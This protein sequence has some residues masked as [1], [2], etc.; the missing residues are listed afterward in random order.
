MRETPRYLPLYDINEPPPP[1][2]TTPQAVRGL[3][4]ISRSQPCISKRQRQ[5]NEEEDEDDALLNSIRINETKLK[6]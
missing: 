3:Q 4:P 6:K 5:S 2:N 1:P